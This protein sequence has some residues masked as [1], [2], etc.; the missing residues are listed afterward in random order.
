MKRNVYLYVGDSPRR[1][2]IGKD[3]F[4]LLNWSNGDLV[5]PAQ[6]KNSWSRQITLPG[7]Q[8][9]DII[10][11]IFHRSDRVTVHDAIGQ[12]IGFD[13]ARRTPFTV[14]DDTFS[15]VESGYIKLDAVEVNGA[16][17]DYK[18][19]LYGGIGGFLY[20]LAYTQ[21]GSRKSL[22]DL[23]YKA[24]DGTVQS[25]DFTISESTVQTAWDYLKNKSWYDYLQNNKWDFINFAPAYNG[26]PKGSFTPNK[27]ILKD[28]A[29]AGLVTSLTEDGKTYGPGFGGSVIATF[30]EA[31][32]EW[33]VKDVRS[34]LQRPIFR[35]MAILEACA[36]PDNNGGYTVDLDEN[37]F[38][39]ALAGNPYVC[40]TWV[41]LPQLTTLDLQ[42]EGQRGTF[43]SATVNGNGSKTYTIPSPGGQP[44]Q[45]VINVVPKISG[46]GVK[47]YLDMVS[48]Q[49]GGV[50]PH[51]INWIEIQV[52]FRQAGQLI[53]SETYRLSSAQVS[54]DIMPLGGRITH[55]GYFD[56]SGNWVGPPV[57]VSWFDE[58]AGNYDQV[59]IYVTSDGTVEDA[60]GYNPIID[61]VWDNQEDGVA[62]SYNLATT[63]SGYYGSSLS[64]SARSFVNVQSSVLLATEYTPAD[65]LLSFMKMLG[66]RFIWD[67]AQKKVTITSRYHY[68]DQ[69]TVTDIS[70]RINR[71]KTMTKYPFSFDK[72]FYAWGQKYA[73]G[74]W[75]KYYANVYGR[76]YGT[77]T[78]DTG[79]EFDA[80]TRDVMDSVIFR[81]AVQILESSKYYCN[82]ADGGA[83]MPSAFLDQGATYDL[84]DA[85]GKTKQM[86]IPSPS[87]QA[88][89]TW[90]N[91]THPQFDAFDKPQFHNEGNASFDNRDTLLFFCDMQDVTGK[92]Y[93]LTDDDTAQ[94]MLN[95]N[96]PCWMLDGGTPLTKIPHFS[97]YTDLVDGVYQCSLDFGTPA[98]IP[99]P[100]V[101]FTS[102][103]ALYPRN[104][105]AFITDRYD[106]DS[107]VMHCFV[108][109]DGLGAIGQGLLR[110]FYYFDDAIWSL[111]KII[112]YSMTTWDDTECEFV[113]VQDVSNYQ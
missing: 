65:Y 19:T 68:Y 41:T 70:K 13:A 78:V 73:E 84:Y 36:D 95:N 58:G 57:Q 104:W 22:A 10:F 34:Y 109:L 5:D 48:D 91:T 82:V 49:G 45:Y 111:N 39:P 92:G 59:D 26:L 52:S 21:D 89:K 86:A 100:G 24:H 101:A 61:T 46:V 105:R 96:T 56:A 15:P 29:Y 38:D 88:V 106:D 55:I 102:T 107:P 60:P 1:V 66:L 20:S 87:E 25:L 2:D 112:N 18:C 83:V 53:H 40:K 47:A 35:M 71:G 16:R 77:H 110:N 103:A 14:Y 63:L 6:I 50:Y 80:S 7:T 17:H 113:K 43:S 64:A 9:N 97:R 42:I 75:A 72:R 62:Y 93:R 67:G 108:N 33:E 85:D 98:E 69:G 44:T 27:G 30:P 90:I 32:T 76:T 79:Y 31:K 8:N 3:T 74:E 54:A 23:V 4:V 51:F 99:V 28:P 94:M 37:T 11:G 12:G 81:G